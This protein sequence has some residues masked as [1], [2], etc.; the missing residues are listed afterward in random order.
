MK[1]TLYESN[2]NAHNRNSN[3]LLRP[4][5]KPAERR[6]SWQHSAS[7]QVFDRPTVRRNLSSLWSVSVIVTV[8]V[9]PAAVPSSGQ[10]VR[11]M[12]PG[13]DATD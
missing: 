5:L 13:S 6:W 11:L 12:S 10:S 2:R 9:P 4:A 3:S 8:T 7:D 1:H